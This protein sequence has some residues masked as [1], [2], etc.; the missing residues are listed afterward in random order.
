MM[1]C[2]FTSPEVCSV[3][4]TEEQ[5]RNEHV[6]LQIGRSDLHDNDRGLTSG[7][8]EGFVKVI[9]DPDG[10]LLGGVMVGPRAGEVMHE[11][12]LAVQLRA[13]GSDIAGLVHAFPTFSEALGGACGALKPV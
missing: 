7:Q 9:A 10:V 6:S 8:R 4:L 12:A 2:V 13:K 3:G 5:A 1:R 11:L